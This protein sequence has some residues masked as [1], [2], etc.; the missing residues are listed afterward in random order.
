MTDELL[1]A[2]PGTSAVVDWFG[3]WPAFHDAEI[4]QLQ[5]GSDAVLTFNLYAWNMTSEID[6]KGY[7]RNEKHANVEFRLEE[8][9]AINLLDFTEIGVLFD[10]NLE[11][12]DKQLTVTMSSSYGVNG[13]ITCARCSVKLKPR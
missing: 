9:S 5:L 8:V 11:L 3:R 7:Y 10:L 13:T 2:I 4:S 1:A 12:V 6:E